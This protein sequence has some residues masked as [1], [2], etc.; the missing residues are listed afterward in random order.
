MIKRGT[1][2]SVFIGLTMLCAAPSFAQKS[3]L[4]KETTTTLTHL[5]D[6]MVAMADSMALSPVNDDRIDFCVKFT[7]DL[8]TAM[9]VPGSFQYPFTRLASKIHIIY[10]EDK[11][12]R[13]FNWLI[14][15]AQDLRRYYGAVQMNTEEPKF[16]PLM[17]G[18]GEFTGDIETQTFDNK[19]WLGCEF[20]KIMDQNLNGRKAYILF[21]YNSN[22]MKSN[23]KILDVLSFDENGL[24]LGAPIFFMPDMLGQR[25]VRKDRVVFE[26]KK[27]AQIYLNYDAERKMIIFNRLASEVTDPNRKSTYI[28]TGQMDGLKWQGDSYQFVKEAIPVLKLQDGQAP[29]DGVMKGG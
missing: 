9:Q 3:T 4:D 1:L 2:C 23:K 28:P 24:V 13:I 8:K 22:G 14:A 7:K 18:N 10:P 29:I 17:D 27:T 25:L 15:P 20:Y 11:S 6:S 26:Y 19:H 16:Y 12:F 21:G 5:E